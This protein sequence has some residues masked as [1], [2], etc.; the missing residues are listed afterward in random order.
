[1]SCTDPRENTYIE[2][3]CI[4]RFSCGYD[5]CMMEECP[6]YEAKTENNDYY[7][8]DELLERVKEIF[9]GGKNG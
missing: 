4:Y 2:N 6:E 8:L 9:I 1:M 3:P 5:F 7:G